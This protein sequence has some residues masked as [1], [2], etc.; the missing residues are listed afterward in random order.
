MKLQ[1][2]SNLERN[3]TMEKNINLRLYW[4]TYK[5]TPIRAIDEI[6]DAFCALLFEKFGLESEHELT[7]EGIV[8]TV[9]SERLAK[10]LDDLD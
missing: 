2:Q 6:A 3:G 1:S 10:A 4:P 7:S 5:D 8:I 9:E